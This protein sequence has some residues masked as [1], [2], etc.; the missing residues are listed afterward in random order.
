MGS[1]NGP[2]RV[3]H[4][5]PK[6]STRLFDYLIRDSLFMDGVVLQ[7]SIYMDL[8]GLYGNATVFL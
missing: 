8:Y 6:L 7:N 5:Q 4:M 1:T 2:G 3:G